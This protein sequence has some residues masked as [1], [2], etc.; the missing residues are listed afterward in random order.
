MKTTIVTTFQLEGIH[1]WPEAQEIE[2]AVDFLSFPHRH[3]FFF[4]TW[5]EVSH[6][7]RDIEIILFKRAQMNHLKQRYNQGSCLDFGRRSCEEIAKELIEQF[8]LDA[9]EV[10]EDNENGAYVSIE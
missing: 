10:L 7:D 2:P 5:K 9:C 6:D 4:K 3:T 8:N 1:N